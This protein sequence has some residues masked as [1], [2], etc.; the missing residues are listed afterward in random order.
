MPL[1][2]LSRAL[3]TMGFTLKRGTWDNK[4]A[5][6]YQFNRQFIEAFFAKKLGF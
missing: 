2:R 3:D 1:I 4:H 5:R 6:V